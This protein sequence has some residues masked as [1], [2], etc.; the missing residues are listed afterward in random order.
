MARS[1][2]RVGALAK[3]REALAYNPS[4]RATLFNIAISEALLA[5]EARRFPE[6]LSKA[7]EALR[8][9][10]DAS[11][12][13]WVIRLE[14]Y[15]ADRRVASFRERGLK[16][17]DE[18]RY[19]DAE[20]IW[21][22]AIR[23]NPTSAEF[24]YELGRALEEQ[25][26]F[27]EAEVFYSQGTRLDP[28][29]PAGHF[30]LGYARLMLGRH[31]EAEHAYRA[32]ARFDPTHAGTRANLGYVLEKQGKQ[33]EAKSEYREAARLDPADYWPRR[34]LGDVLRSEGNFS[35]A[36]THYKDAVRL[37]PKDG[38][39]RFGLAR[40]L[41]ALGDKESAMKEYRETINVDPKSVGARANLAILLI[42]DGKA[43]EAEPLLRKVIELDP[44]NALGY[45]MLGHALKKQGRD[46]EA[47]ESYRR[48]LALDP[49]D[50]E[51]VW[52]LRELRTANAK[53]ADEVFSGL[54]APFPA[55]NEDRSPKTAAAPPLRPA[56]G[57]SAFQQLL[58]LD[59]QGRQ[60]KAV[61]PTNTPVGA[62]HD[63]ASEQAR[64]VLD[65]PIQAVSKTDRPDAIDALKSRS[66]YEV[67][68]EFADKPDIKD[69][70]TRRRELEQRMEE[71]R[72]IRTDLERRRAAE[73][74]QRERAEIDVQLT[75]L[76]LERLNIPGQIH[77]LVIQQQQAVEQYRKFDVKFGAAGETARPVGASAQPPAVGRSGT[78]PS[79]TV[80]PTN[81]PQ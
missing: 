78:G 80:A 75:K 21:T 32:A 34:R 15:L 8:Y 45:R 39:A 14:R 56:G 5:N 29:G 17:L 30:G 62:V 40:S 51:A 74:D 16:A 43:R 81:K 20:A 25:R 4:D 44:R 13:D 66:R 35:E 12:R 57:G 19:R 41:H 73:A 26:R 59:E 79:T 6:A 49:A 11:I 31:A 48:V 70:T 52:Q 71:I 3:Y 10:D 50:R 55:G 72:R 1:G 2:D 42:A 9:R 54:F 69:M 65:T 33:A 24:H 68:K 46:G 36:L 60:A 22:A 67:P 38:D 7:R 76:D 23:E 63:P 58:V 77:V 37:N 28:T 47:Q 53:K 27:A 61:K 64:N 18:G